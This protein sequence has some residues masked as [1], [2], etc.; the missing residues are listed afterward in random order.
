[1]NGKQTAVW[2]FTIYDINETLKEEKMKTRYFLTILIA[3]SLV[4]LGMGAGHPFKAMLSGSSEVASVSSPAK[5]EAVFDL[6]KD[7]KEL[8]YKVTVSDIENVTAAHVHKGAMGKDGPP[9]ALIDIKGKKEGV[10]S[11]TL[12]E[13]TITDKD[14]LGPMK[15]KSVK[16]L[17]REL[18]AG[19]TYVNVH[20]AKYP[21][22]ELRGQIKAD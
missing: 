12:A 21:D 16:D 7:G 17:A 2:R 10:F 11:G 9:L 4:S 1:V 13:G 14:L 3:L 18:K 15:G 19:D 8:K 5:G 22:G 6:D 20:T